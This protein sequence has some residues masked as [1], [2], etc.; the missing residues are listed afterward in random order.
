MYLMF[1]L[2]LYAQ[3]FLEP[4]PP[5]LLTWSDTLAVFSF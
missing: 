4:E 3:V 2:D 5:H 1:K